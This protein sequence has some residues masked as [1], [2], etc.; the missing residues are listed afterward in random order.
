MAVAM[1]FHL[2]D[3]LL[4]PNTRFCIVLLLLNFPNQH[5]YVSC[6]KTF[7]IY[8]F[9][10]LNLQAKESNEYQLFIA[11]IYHKRT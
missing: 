9:L 10:I 5:L 1:G 2:K 11:G 8:V 3:I 4:H 6:Q 7:I